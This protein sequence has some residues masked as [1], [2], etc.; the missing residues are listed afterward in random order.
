[1][2]ST[3][4]T[5]EPVVRKAD[6]ETWARVRAD[7]AQ[8]VSPRLLAER[9]GVGER[10]VRRR[11][12]AEGWTRAPRLPPEGFAPGEALDAFDTARRV[13]MNELLLRPTRHALGK[14]AF[15]RATEAAAFGRPAEATHWLRLVDQLRRNARAVDDATYSADPADIIRAGYAESLFFADHPTLVPET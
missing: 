6:E 5:S 3:D 14:F 15:R 7:Y 12:S 2:I 9:H 8:G 11:A 10:N 1:M 4:I 13:E